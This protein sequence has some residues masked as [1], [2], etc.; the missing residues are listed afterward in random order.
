VSSS[1]APS[2]GA[3]CAEQRAAE[4]LD[5]ETLYRRHAQQVGRWAGRLAGNGTD[6]EDLVHQ[7]FLVAHR[8]LA[9]FRG[10]AKVTT[11]LHGITVRVVQ[12]ARRRQRRTFWP[13]RRQ[14]TEG[15]GSP[16]EHDLT[17]T[18]AAD[19]PSALE[20][21]ERKEAGRVV[22]EVL[23]QMDEKYRTTLILFELEGLSGQQVAE[24]TKTSLSNVWVRLLRGRQQ[25][26]K[27]FRAWE[28]QAT[29]VGPAPAKAGATS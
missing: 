16:A 28:S 22:Y 21:L 4:A 6:V 11:W 7:V 5:V 20:L 19:E 25:F 15:G 1:L 17:E 23:N 12:E 9:D 18:L 13:L 26:V 27:R 3:P 14:G 2:T 10:D 29:T 8:R 24:V